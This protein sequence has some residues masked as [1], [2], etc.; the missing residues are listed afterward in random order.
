MTTVEFSRP[1]ALAARLVGTDTS[2]AEH[3]FVTKRVMLRLE[4]ELAS[5]KSARE[6]LILLANEILR[7]CP[8]IIVELPAAAGGLAG[9]LEQLAISIHGESRIATAAHLSGT[10]DAIVN[11]GTEI[12]AMATWITVNADGWVSRC[13]AF[14]SGATSTLPRAYEHPNPFGALGAACLGAGQAFQALIGKRVLANPTEVSLYTLEQ[15]TP[16]ELHLGPELPADPAELDV[17]LIGCGGVASGWLY[18]IRRAPAAGR[19]EAVDHQRLRDE[20]LGAYVCA[21]RSRLSQPK[22]QIA[23]EELGRTFTVVTRAER[24]R[25]FKARFAYGQSYIP[26]LVI[27]AL[28]KAGVRHQVQR[29]WA[30]ITID[31][32]AEGLTSQLIIKRRDDNGMCVIEAHTEPAGADAELAELATATGLSVER[33]HDF[34]SQIT[35]EDIAAA[36]ASKR[37]G[38]EEARRQRRPICGRVGDLDLNEEEYT[39]NFTPAV[40]FVTAFAGIVG[41]AQTMKARL[42]PLS[43]LHF[44]FSFS[45]Y[46]SRTLKM[47]S[48]ENCECAPI[49]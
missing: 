14:N 21:T 7:F 18:S 41:A 37:P 36:P 26:E 43:S 30:P 32:A 8:N 22:V 10:P 20:N 33:L 49:R 34:E 29:L 25:F 13:A 1:A 48:S 24:F 47:H 45:S 38:L 35:E 19:V 39:S 28:D 46:R 6:T 3:L 27:S 9:V 23:R 11:V 15:G 44:Q 16:G 31:L 12:R 42:E 5:T 2:T 40:P 4:E 17:L